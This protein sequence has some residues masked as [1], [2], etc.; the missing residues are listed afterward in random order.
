MK[1]ITKRN[2]KDKIF[3]FLGLFSLLIGL[4][5]LILLIF[6]I[7]K[8]G[9]TSL[10]WHF[11]FGQL[12]LANSAINKMDVGILNAILGSLLA[13]TLAMLIAIPFGVLAGIYLEEYLTKKTINYK[14]LSIII[15]NLNG[16][17]SV[18]YGLLGATIFL[19]FQLRGTV[20]AAGFTL[21]LLTLPTIIVIT[22]EALKT[23][24]LSLKEAAYGLG[25]TKWQ[26]INATTLPYAKSNIV[27]GIIFSLSRALGETAPLVMIGVSVSVSYNPQSFT[28]KIA[29]I[30]IIINEFTTSP[31]TNGLKLAAATSIVLLVIILIFNLIA[32]K[33]R[34]NS[35]KNK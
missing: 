25:M 30:P 19:F 6:S 34:I 2:F 32:V 8:S 16:V 35:Q 24:P 27:T 26:V 21:S 9:L 28:D 4:I 7:L 18:I 31:N 23:V 11:L 10:N 22:Q 13:V 12:Q 20:L 1:Q 15:S 5:F 29:A 14:L 17:P 33:I 3:E